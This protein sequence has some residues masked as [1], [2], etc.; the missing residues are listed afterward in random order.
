L[1]AGIKKPAVEC[2]LLRI[3]IQGNDFLKDTLDTVLPVV[4]LW[5]FGLVTGIEF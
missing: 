5:I 2:G 1:I 4:F 3:L